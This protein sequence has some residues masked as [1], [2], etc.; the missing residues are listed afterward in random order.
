MIDAI[1]TNTV[2]PA[3]SGEFL[4]RMMAGRPAAGVHIGVAGSDFTYAFDHVPAAE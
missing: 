3:L 2:L 1:L 4:T